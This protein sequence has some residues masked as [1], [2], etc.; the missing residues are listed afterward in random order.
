MEVILLQKIGRLGNLGDKVAVKA[1]FARNFLVPEGKAVFATAENLTKFEARRAEL[2]K[3]ADTNLKEAQVRAEKLQNLAIT[4][5]A[6]AADEG[7]LY[8]SLGT[9][10][11]A[12]AIAKAGIAIEKSEIRLPNGPIRLLGE[13]EII[14]QLHSDVTAQVKVNVVPD[15]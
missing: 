14:V 10:D 8:G 4:I 12:E 1:G 11:I 15:A 9:R 5:S 6:R 3:I 13:H 2:E 7:R